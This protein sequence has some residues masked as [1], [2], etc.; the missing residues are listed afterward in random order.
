MAELAPLLNPDV[1]LRDA[2]LDDW[3]AHFGLQAGERHHASADAQVTAEL[4]LILFSQAR[5]QHIDSP[6]LLEHRLQGWRRRR[7]H[8]HGF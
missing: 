1:V 6:L 8:S 4:A 7:Q 2:G 3:T 5:R